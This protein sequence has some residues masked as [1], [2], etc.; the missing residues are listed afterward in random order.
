MMNVR[1]LINLLTLML[2]LGSLA[3]DVYAVEFDDFDDPLS[4]SE[5]RSLQRAFD[6]MIK[7][8]SMIKY[9]GS[10]LAAVFSAWGA[11]LLITGGDNQQKRDE[12]KNKISYSVMGLGV[13]WAIPVLLDFLF[14]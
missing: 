9:L 5:K 12:A 6:P 3:Y 10:I 4:S 14:N 11:A 7:L 1:V 2:V 13:L 8:F